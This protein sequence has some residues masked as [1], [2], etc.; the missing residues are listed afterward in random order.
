MD[1]DDELM[2]A[3]HA[4]QQLTDSNWTYITMKSAKDR[5]GGGRAGE[6][7]GLRKGGGGAGVDEKPEENNESVIDRSDSFEMDLINLS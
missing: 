3:R 4:E 5:A 2:T 7:R 1:A 6:H